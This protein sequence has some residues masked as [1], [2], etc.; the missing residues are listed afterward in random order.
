[1]IL[2]RNLYLEHESV[3]FLSNVQIAQQLSV[4]RSFNQQ[5]QKRKTR[6]FYGNQIL[7]TGSNNLKK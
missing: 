4:L 2:L 1:M 6:L 7:S 5:I 3:N